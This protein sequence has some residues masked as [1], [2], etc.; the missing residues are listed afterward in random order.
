MIN[1]TTVAEEDTGKYLLTKAKNLFYCISK[2]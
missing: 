2:D 1:A